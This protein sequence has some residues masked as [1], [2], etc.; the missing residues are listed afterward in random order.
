MTNKDLSQLQKEYKSFFLN[1]LKTYNVSSPAELS[2]EKKSDFFTSIKRDWTTIKQEK[3]HYRSFPEANSNIVS[4]NLPPTLQN[5]KPKAGQLAHNEELDTF[6]KSVPNAEQTEDLTIRYFPNSH[7][8]QGPNYCY[9]VVKMPKYN[10]SL[11]LPRLGRTNQR[12]YKEKEFSHLLKLHLT[13]LEV[14]DNVHMVIPHFKRPYEPDIVLFDKHRNLYID[15]E[16]DEPYD[17]LY[18]FPT[19]C[20]KF[21]ESFKQDDIRDLFFNESGWI[22]IRFTEK[23]VHLQSHEC[24]D[25]IKNIIASISDMGFAMQANCE[26][27]NQWDENQCIQW[28]KSNYRE[29]Y[30][31]I[32]GFRRNLD[33]NHIEIDTNENEA[34][35]EVIQ[36]TEMFNPV[37][38]GSEVAFDEKSHIYLNPKDKTGNAQYISVTTLI[39]RFFPFDLKRYVEKKAAEE[40]RS[41]EEVLMEFL[42]VR[43]EAAERGTYPQGSRIYTRHQRIESILEFY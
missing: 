16:I 8:A 31:G 27:E 15:I 43:D 29:K 5:S 34:I 41:E 39:E 1:K 2:R 23:Q 12:G 42:M 20:I 35:E 7:F 40:D 25:Y 37:A 4:E 26:T 32:T 33:C 3:K 18:R 13:G 11:K 19:H 14:T 22:V 10:A 30:L 38:F 21:E 6:Y 9:P 28:Q 36:R 24:I 17:G